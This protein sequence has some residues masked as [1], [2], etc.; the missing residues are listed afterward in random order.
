MPWTASD[1]ISKTRKARSPSAKAQWAAIANSVFAKT[2]DDAKA[3]RIANGVLKRG[4]AKRR[5]RR[6]KTFLD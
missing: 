1:A 2:G 5:K 4:P 3:I 6:G